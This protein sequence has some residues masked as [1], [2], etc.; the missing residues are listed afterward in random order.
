MLIC[1]WNKW[2]ER[3]KIANGGS[4]EG[5]L[6]KHAGVVAACLYATMNFVMYI[7]YYCCGCLPLMYC[8]S[9]S[10]VATNHPTFF[11]GCTDV[12]SKQ[13]KFGTHLSYSL[14]MIIYLEYI[15]KWCVYFLMLC[16]VYVIHC[17]LL[18]ESK[19][20]FFLNIHDLATAYSRC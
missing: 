7:L 20:F 18:A 11:Q 4:M 9:I 17:F 13:N 15:L 14:H 1:G 3:E 10:I 19:G 6:Y 12:G 5:F 8:C 2:K 16:F